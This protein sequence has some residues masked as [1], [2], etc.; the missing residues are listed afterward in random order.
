[1]SR[2]RNSKWRR[3]IGRTQR[4][5]HLKAIDHAGYKDRSPQLLCECLLCK[6]TRIVDV[7]YFKN[8]RITKCENCADPRFREGHAHTMQLRLEKKYDLGV[9]P[10]HENEFFM[11]SWRDRLKAFTFEQRWLFETIVDGRQE[12][13]TDEDEDGQPVKINIW[14]EAVDTVLR[15]PDSVWALNYYE[16][17]RQDTGE[18]A[19]RQV[20]KPESI[21][22]GKAA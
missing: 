13:D 19:A 1:M 11:R 14:A 10:V 22:Y 15:E 5:G 8:E 9:D 2:P 17:W 20:F 4:N 6:G 18:I 3:W 21:Q 12:W 7:R 16:D